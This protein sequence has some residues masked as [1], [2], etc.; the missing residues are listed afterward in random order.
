MLFHLTMRAKAYDHSHPVGE[1]REENRGKQGQS[2]AYDTYNGADDTE[3][4]TDT[5]ELDT[6]GRSV[7]S[8][9][10]TPN[11]YRGVYPERSRRGGAWGYITDPSGMLQLGARYYWPEI[12]RFISQDPI[13]EGGSWYAYAGSNPLTHIDPTGE[14]WYKPWTWFRRKKCPVRPPKPPCKLGGCCDDLAEIPGMQGVPGW[15]D[16]YLDCLWKHDSGVRY[17]AQ[18]PPSTASASEIV[19]EFAACVGLKV[20]C[21]IASPVAGKLGPII[22]AL[23]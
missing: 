21:K 11:P 15:A 22:G 10:T 17:G 13:G 1:T 20:F 8:S 4:I 9:G 2:P 18:L 16:C 6:F 19:S 3:T 7:S 23:C 14:V 5:Y 12:G